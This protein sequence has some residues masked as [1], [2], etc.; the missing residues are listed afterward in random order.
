MTSRCCSPPELEHLVDPLPDLVFALPSRGFHYVIEVHEDVAVG[1]QL[2]ILKHDAE[3][4]AQGREVLPFQGAHGIS[5]YPCFSGIN[6][7]LTVD[8][9]QESRLSAA[10]LSDEID[11]FAFPEFQVYVRKNLLSLQAHIYVL[12]RNEWL[13]FHI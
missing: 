7:H 5:Q 10:H 13:F 1:Q 12:V 9:F 6:L 2:V 11:K 3:F 8:G 4:P